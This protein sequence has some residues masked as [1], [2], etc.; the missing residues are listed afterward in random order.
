MSSFKKI[1]LVLAPLLFLSLFPI[2]LMAQSNAGKESMSI[3]GCLKQGSDTGGYYIMSE[4]KMYE[5]MAHGV[6]LAEHVGHTVTVTG[7]EVKL[8]EAQETKKE[9]SEKSEAGSTPYADFRASSV[10]MVSTSCSQ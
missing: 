4:G 2:L 7:H 1:S 5:V 9:A 10:K 6:N 8:P 3:T